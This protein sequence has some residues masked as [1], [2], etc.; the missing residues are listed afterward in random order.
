MLFSSATFLFRFFPICLIGYYLLDKKFKNIF[1]LLMSLIFYAWGEPKFIVVMLISIFANY[2]FGLAVD[3]FREKRKAAY[4]ILML[5]AVWNIGIFFV[6]K[7]LNFAIRNI[8]FFFQTEI[9]LTEFVLPIGISFF[10]FQAMSYVVDVYRQKGEVQKNPLNVAL[11][12]TFFP[13]LIAGPIV[14]YET[15]ANE[16]RE[17]KENLKDF[18]SGI[19]RFVCGLAKKMIL[20]N[21]VAVIAD[22]IFDAAD[23]SAIS[24]LGAWLGAVCYTLQIYF[25]FSGYSDMAIGLGRMFGFHFNENF[26]YPYCS[27]TV[28]EF[29]R[30]WHISLGTW[31]RDYVYFPLGGSRVKRKGRLIFNL[32]VVWLLTGIWH[33]ASWNFVVWGL[34]YFVILTFEKLSGIG[35]VLKNRKGLAVLYRVFTLFAVMIGWVLFRSE[36]L[37]SALIYMKAMFGLN[38]NSLSDFQTNYHLLHYVL[39][40]VTAIILSTP[41][42]QIVRRKLY[43]VAGNSKAE[44]LVDAVEKAVTLML[45]V[46]SLSYS[47][48]TS[49]NP[50]I[51]FN[52]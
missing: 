47:V 11:Y 2:L 18:V 9:P 8:N 20:S 29:W 17:R 26:N 15:V 36:N 31:F 1:L 23:V 19:S 13:Q 45:A 6:Y 33:G 44:I 52:F 51:Y 46:V 16:M 27:A 3:K 12:I 14:R 32:F 39:I 22:M 5:M 40:I 49:Y 35:E 41:I 38:Q 25:D 43:A 50:F 7:Y 24:V 30:R 37:T 28:S 10:T 21:S 48:C 42:V 34:F 4:A